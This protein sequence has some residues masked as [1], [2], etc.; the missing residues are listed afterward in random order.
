MIGQ[1]AETTFVVSEEQTAIYLGS[2]D[3]SVLGTPALLVAMEATAVRALH[4]DIGQTSVGMHVS[5]DHLK[6][7]AVGQMVTIQAEITALEERRVTFQIKAFQGEDLIGECTHIR[8]I[9]NR[10]K[11]LSR[12]TN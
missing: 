9:V 3:V 1:Q 6:A 12:L 8:A 7:T 4:L 5:L 10:E 2:G 11:F